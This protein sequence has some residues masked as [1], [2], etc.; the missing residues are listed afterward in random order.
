[1]EKDSKKNIQE[2]LRLKREYSEAIQNGDRNEALSIFMR[3]KE[4]YTI[5]TGKD[6]ES[7]IDPEK[8]KRLKEYLENNSALSNERNDPYLIK[9]ISYSDKPTDPE[10]EQEK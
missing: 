3:L 6:L 9:E 4:L 10:E 1:M 8:M 5:E 7:L 2:I